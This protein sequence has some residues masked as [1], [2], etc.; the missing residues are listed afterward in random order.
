MMIQNQT[1]AHIGTRWRGYDVINSGD[2][3]AG[4]TGE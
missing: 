1:E 3:D 2:M 4:C